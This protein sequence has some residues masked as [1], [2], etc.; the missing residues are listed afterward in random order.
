[1]DFA[2]DHVQIAIPVAGED[3]ARRYF[4]DLLGLTEI[5]KPADMA[6][7]GGCWFAVGALQLHIGVE[8]EFRAAKKAHVALRCDSLDTLRYRL[9]NAGFPTH[10]D[11]VIDGRHR[12]FSF[13]P[14]GNRI[15]FMDREPR[16]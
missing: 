1:L 5:T 13:D 12:F 2:I 9:E 3:E 15:E 4:G 14:F 11:S 8:A 16:I 10:D 6:K 7:R